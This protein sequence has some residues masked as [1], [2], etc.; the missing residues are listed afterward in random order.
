MNTK[1]SIQ[2]RSLILWIVDQI[3]YRFHILTPSIKRL[4]SFCVNFYKPVFQQSSYIVTENQLLSWIS[5]SLQAKDY[6]VLVYCKFEGFPNLLQNHCRYPTAN[7]E[8]NKRKL[9][10]HIHGC[11][12]SAS[13]GIGN[14]L[15]WGLPSIFL[16]L[17]LS[18]K[19]KWTNLIWMGF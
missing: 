6:P 5:S 4:H 2:V 11:G 14:F 18:I 13:A 8:V 15:L 7:T 19:L 3:Y 12:T 1:H 10:T 16:I 9:I 17:I